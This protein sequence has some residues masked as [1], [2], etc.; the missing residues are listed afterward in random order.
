MRVEANGGASM[1]GIRGKERETETERDGEVPARNL[2]PLGHQA[3][4]VTGGTREQGEAIQDLTFFNTS[5][6]FL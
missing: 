2:D 6:L 1:Q 5:S 4:V 3:K